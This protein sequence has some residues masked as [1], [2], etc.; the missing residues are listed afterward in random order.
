MTQQEITNKQTEVKNFMEGL[1]KKGKLNFNQYTED[2]LKTVFLL[3]LELIDL[4]IRE[5]PSNE[6]ITEVGETVKYLM[7]FI[8]SPDPGR[9][10][11][12]ISQHIQA[13]GKGNL[14]RS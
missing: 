12:Y 3:Y 13:R 8:N 11:K 2:E 10:Q 7:P 14:F 5:N 9:S 4:L 1:K 6:K